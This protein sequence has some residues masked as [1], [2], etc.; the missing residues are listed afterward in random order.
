MLCVKVD[1]W[2]GLNSIVLKPR[3]AFKSKQPRS[4]GLFRTFPWPFPQARVKAL[5]TRLK[6]DYAR[7][8]FP[9]AGQMENLIRLN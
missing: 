5:G 8:F 4:Q 1:F 6:S 2:R 3:I 9:T 7:T